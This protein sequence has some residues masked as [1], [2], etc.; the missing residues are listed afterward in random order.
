MNANVR[1][2]WESIYSDAATL[3]ASAFVE[4]WPVINLQHPLTALA[5]K[6]PDGTGFVKNSFDEPR[7][8]SA[9]ALIGHNLGI[10]STVTIRVY[11]D[12][13]L[14]EIFSQTFDV[15]KPV[16]TAGE[17]LP[18][19]SSPLG[20]PSAEDLAVLPRTTSVFFLDKTFCQRCLKVEINNG[21]TAFHVG[22][23]ILCKHFEP[24]NNFSYGW[25][26]SPS[27]DSTVTRAL[28][29]QDWVDDKA[30]RCGYSFSLGSLSKGEVDGPLKKMRNHCGRSR[31]L[32]VV[33]DPD[34][35]IANHAVY[36]KFKMVP[37]VTQPQH[38]IYTANFNIEEAL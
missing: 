31:P 18:C 38:G 26:D 29:G 3:E 36:C 37:A 4:G 12:A 16:Y 13:F 14:T 28:G 11:D 27:D 32:V 22:R 25:R 34:N 1:F 21:A 35:P 33:L 24:Q 23:M 5:W 9:L 8:V 7:M 2:L 15:I 30:R 19:N 6:C 10:G 20:Y 17:I